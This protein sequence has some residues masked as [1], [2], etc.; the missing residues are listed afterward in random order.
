MLFRTRRLAAVSVA[1][2]AAT[3]L[4]AGCTSGSAST[5]GASGDTLTLWTH[6]AG[7][8]V[9]LDVVKKI[10]KDFNG[11]Q[12]KYK[13]KLQAFPQSD[14]NNSVVAAASAR[15]L[16]CLLDV[17]GPNVANWAW[18]GYLD[19]IDVSGSEV[20][21]LSQ[22]ASTVGRY[23]DKLYAFGFYDV[24]LAYFARKSV[25]NANGVRVPTMDKPW[26]KDE[27]NAAL[28]K[29]KK[30]GKFEY[31]LEMGTGGTGEWWSYA[32]SPQLQSF[33]GD[34][35]DRGDYK[36][37]S[38]TLDGEN[39]VEWAT[40]FHSLVAKDYMA[41][42][43]GADPNKDFLAGKS[44]IQW[45]GSWNAAKN[46]EKLGDDLAII[47]PV[48]F[49][50]GPKIG[51]ASWQWGMSSTCSNKA[52]AQAWLKF[53]RQTKYFVDYAKATSTIP[54]TDAAAQQIAD[55]QPG[56]KFDVLVQFARK[57]AMVRP[58]TPAYPYISTEFEKA[59]KDILA[60]ADPK[61]A[62]GQA[63]KSIDNNLKTNNYYS[64]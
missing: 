28:A 34:L 1:V 45:D 40:W 44:A 52:G 64:N 17:D 2:T 36:T 20:P 57:Y 27:F 14:Y 26:T 15:K 48:D 61:D 30:S 47:P 62:L 60:G 55:Y 29:L 46:A 54:A 9:E 51:G 63:A 50:N 10:I 11:S 19:P 12:D 33:G 25:L 23:N 18:G 38:G 5:S 35:I 6:N 13:V 3:A 42:K 32:Y 49:G 39:A 8:S 21:V 58:A 41:K 24:S 37:A 16:P 43:S 56:G 31:P 7:N 22:L 53:S 59:S 4:V